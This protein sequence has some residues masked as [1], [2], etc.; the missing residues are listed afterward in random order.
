MGGG[1][2]ATG[3]G[4]F[5]RAAASVVERIETLGGGGASTKSS[6]GGGVFVSNWP[7]GL[8]GSEAGLIGGATSVSVNRAIGC[9][10]IYYENGED[11]LR[12]LAH[13]PT[14]K[15]V[16]LAVKPFRAA[17]GV[18]ANSGCLPE[19]DEDGSEG[20]EYPEGTRV[21]EMS[22]GAKVGF[23][24]WGVKVQTRQFKIVQKESVVG[25]DGKL[26]PVNNGGDAKLFKAVV[27][28]IPPS[29]SQSAVLEAFS[30]CGRIVESEFGA[31]GEGKSQFAVIE[32]ANEEALT[33]TPRW[34]D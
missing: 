33:V 16:Q 31:V 24:P 13:P 8:K 2:A 10:V 20:A 5:S 11:A 30:A 17:P 3:A 4:A 12:A 15:G 22:A 19:S 26:H 27:H 29:S 21:V 34:S 25:S 28:G 7:E 23:D 1:Q 9:A 18:R 6:K 14:V 32:F